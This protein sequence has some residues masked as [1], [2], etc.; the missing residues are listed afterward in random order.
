ME[1][2]KIKIR[3]SGIEDLFWLVAVLFAVAIF[4]VILYFV[5]GRV[6]PKIDE[7]LSGV[8]PNDG[9]NV[10][11]TLNKTTTSITRFNTLFP[12]ILIGL[13]A[14]VIMSAFF[15]E[16]HPIFFWVGLILLGVALIFGAVFSNVYKQI[17][18]NDEIAAAG[19]EFGVVNLFMKYLPLFVLLVFV[20]IGIVLWSKFTGGSGGGL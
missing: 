8:M 12:L 13:F 16:S 4:F 9:V 14:F 7:G 2:R 20:V 17:T 10:T 18:E 15:L 19:A 3:N 11:Q 5:W 6:S 1:L